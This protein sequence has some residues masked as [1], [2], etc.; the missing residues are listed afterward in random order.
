[1]SLVVV[2]FQYQALEHKFNVGGIR[3]GL[4]K[5]QLKRNWSSNSN[6]QNIRIPFPKI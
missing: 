3:I 5:D 1:M 6:F 4:Q 2:D